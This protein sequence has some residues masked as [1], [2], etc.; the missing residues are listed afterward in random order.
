MTLP[1]RVTHEFVELVPATREPGKI[2]I[3]ITFATAVHDCLCGCGSKVVT[4]IKPN[5]W[6]LSFNGETISLSPSIGNWNFPCQS[7]YFIR[8]NQVIAA[9]PM[10][11]EEI[12]SGRAYDETLTTRHYRTPPAPSPPQSTLHKRGF[13]DRLFRR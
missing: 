5:K 10:T 2:Y 6:T 3:S 7:H 8:N 13:W 12:D 11:R 4:P 9:G 1:A